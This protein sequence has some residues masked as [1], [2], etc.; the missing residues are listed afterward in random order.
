MK[1]GKK[2]KLS[3]ILKKWLIIRKYQKK[4]KKCKI[5]GIMGQNKAKL[6]KIGAKLSNIS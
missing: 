6:S 1:I 4:W 3:E 2:I 5:F